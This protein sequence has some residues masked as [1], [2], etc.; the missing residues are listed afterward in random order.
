MSTRGCLRGRERDRGKQMSSAA[1]SCDMCSD[2]D[3][4]QTQIH[5]AML[6]AR[7]REI[8]IAS[9]TG[10]SHKPLKTQLRAEPE[11]RRMSGSL[12]DR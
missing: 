7:A 11:A 8:L 4:S 6:R 1:T 5:R 9:Q 12:S 2:G 3:S 10:I